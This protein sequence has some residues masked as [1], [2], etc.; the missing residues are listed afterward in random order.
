MQLWVGTDAMI[1]LILPVFLVRQHHT[2][3]VAPPVETPVSK[4]PF[5]P[6]LTVHVC[7]CQL[8]TSCVNL[9]PASMPV[10][11]PITLL[12]NTQDWFTRA[13]GQ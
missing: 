2:P 11:P 3:D 12:C 13:T 4:R 8:T 5:K 6:D 7:G 1:V 9:L 10:A